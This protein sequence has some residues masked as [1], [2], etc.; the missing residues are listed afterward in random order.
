MRQ[1]HSSAVPSSANTHRTQN[2]IP[3]K[4][5]PQ[6]KEGPQFDPIDSPKNVYALC[7]AFRMVNAVLV[8]SALATYFNPDEHWQA[9]EVAHRITFGFGHLTWEWKKGIRS[10]LHP[11]LFS[12]LYKL[13]AL[14]G[15][16]TPWFMVK[17]PR[18][19]QSLFSA[20]GELYLYKLSVIFFGDQV[21][22]WAV[23]CV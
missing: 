23:S 10:F 21:T 20:F 4:S 8:H 22:K 12:L 11:L 14:L 17:A 19:F 7:L 15:L 1:R 18:L 3:T 5:Q 16:D 6:E 9:L 13:L 2:P